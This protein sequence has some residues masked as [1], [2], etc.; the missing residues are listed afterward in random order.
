MLA[1]FQTQELRGRA[2]R[3]PQV[4][5]GLGLSF[6]GA[7]FF[8]GPPWVAA[9][10]LAGIAGNELG[11]EFAAGVTRGDG[12]C[13]ALARLN[14]EDVSVRQQGWAGACQLHGVT[15]ALAAALSCG[16]RHGSFVHIKS[17]LRAENQ[18][19]RGHF[20]DAGSWFLGRASPW[21]C[22]GKAAARAEHADRSEG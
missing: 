8:V 16:T 17:Y 14:C 5:F 21:G 9:H 20:G 4:G 6:V 18:G 22:S 1:E 12:V 15:G 2:G 7:A 10:E 19:Q 13:D 3:G 11:R